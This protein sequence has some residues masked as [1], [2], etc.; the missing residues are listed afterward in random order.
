[1]SGYLSNLILR[2]LEPGETVQPRLASRFEPPSTGRSF[3]AHG[4]LGD[5]QELDAPAALGEIEIESEPTTDLLSTIFRPQVA[6]SRAAQSAAPLHQSASALDEHAAPIQTKAAT[7]QAQTPT[8]RQTAF[9]PVHAQPI[10]R[11]APKMNTPTPA[12]ASKPPQI[13]QPIKPDVATPARAERQAQVDA[14]KGGLTTSVHAERVAAIEPTASDG[15]EQH[16][17]P[18]KHETSVTK[19]QDTAPLPQLS[20]LVPAESHEGRRRARSSNKAARAPSADEVGPQERAH[21]LP[22]ARHAQPNERL[23]TD[24]V[25][26]AAGPRPGKATDEPPLPQVVPPDRPATNLVAHPRIARPAGPKVVQVGPDEVAESAPII[27]VTIGRI[28]VRATNAP[29][30]PRRQ[31]AAPLMSLD[32]YLRQR[33][34]G[35]GQ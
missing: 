11:L 22:L 20:A 7:G 27:N 24:G 12:R 33:A 28:E 3:A 18:R 17:A 5:T 4:S 23:I 10:E 32:D 13:V 8:G 19:E 1:M 2:Q 29:P 14:S 21:A 6:P 30:A 26:S 34:G 35:G 25:S 9:E 15:D 31:S 16:R